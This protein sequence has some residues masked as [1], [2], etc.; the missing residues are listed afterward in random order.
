M[1]TSHHNQWNKLLGICSSSLLLFALAM[2]G[3]YGARVYSTGTGTI[4]SIAVPVTI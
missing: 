2:L 1:S 3:G 4:V